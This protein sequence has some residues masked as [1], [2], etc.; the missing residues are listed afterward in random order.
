MP[1]TTQRLKAKDAKSNFGS[2][3][4]FVIIMGMCMWF[5]A[6]GITIEGS[7][8]IIPAF[9][10]LHSVSAAAL[11]SIATV[12]NLIGIP[13]VAL[14]GMLQTKIGPR[15]VVS[16]C[17]AIAVAGLVILGFAQG[18]A[19]YCVGRIVVGVGTSCANYIGLNG[20]IA[21]WFPAK[22]DLAL[23]YVT[24]GSNLS[25]AFSLIIF[26]YL[27][28]RFSLS[29]MFWI[30]AVVF[31]AV[32][33]LSLV[34]F[35]DNPEDVGCW[36]DND[37]S[38]TLEK[39]QELHRQGEEYQ[40][41]SPWTVKAILKTRQCWQIAFGYGIILLIT[42]GILT[43]LV[44]SLIIKGMDQTHA[45]GMMTVAAVCAM[46]CSYLWGFLGTKF[47]TKKAT[48]LLYLV[49]FGT[50][51]FMLVPGTWAIYVT[52]A[53]LGCFIGAGNNLTPA[54][55]ATVYGRYDF[56]KALAVI[57]PIWNIVVAFAT[58]IVGVPQS[59]TGSYTASY[60][61]LLVIAVIGCVLV[62]TLDDRCIGRSDLMDNSAQSNK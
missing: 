29:G 26:N 28:A 42:V 3:G 59:L 22:K 45:I 7:N 4:W 17:W 24:I 38:M 6:A 40:K 56:S 10:Q 18:L 49:V 1:D 52:V 21:N 8:L 46:P 33:V 11:Y 23:G 15:K 57:L 5:F 31:G 12:A 54:I 20:I 19:G 13:L 51:I 25:T 2:R 50:I 53:L 37:R 55:I 62:A 47:S 32:A 44:T 9:S 60:L 34:G 48:L 41:T 58:V 43:T 16:L 36:P 27:I 35:R 39:V 14:F 30:W 61:V